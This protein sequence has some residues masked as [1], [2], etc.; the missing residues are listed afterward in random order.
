MEIRYLKYYKKRMKYG[1]RSCYCWQKHHHDS[2]KE[3]SYCNQLM[4]LKR[5]GEIAKYEIQVDFPLRV[6]KQKICT[7][8]VDFL[9]TNIHGGEEI[10]EVKSNITMTSTWDIKRKLFEVLYPNIPYIVV[11]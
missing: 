7:I 6:R 1:N 4:M 8:R 3:A 9:I 10:H 2:I 5:A 11:R